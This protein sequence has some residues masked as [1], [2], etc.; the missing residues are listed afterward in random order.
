MP[1]NPQKPKLQK[2]QGMVLVSSLVF[3]FV[4]TLL[5]VSAMSG[6]SL[7]IRM[8]SN[9]QDKAFAFQAAEGAL[10][11]VE[12]WLESETAGQPHHSLFFVLTKAGTEEYPFLYNASNGRAAWDEF[13]WTTGTYGTTN[14]M[15]AAS[16]P[17]RYMIEY[18]ASDDVNGSPNQTANQFIVTV[19]G[20]GANPNSR[21]KIQQQYFYLD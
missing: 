20:Y 11:E 7:E 10:L 4:I 13:E 6:N 1:S 2:Q 16:W 3:L 8:A 17:P 12:D 15:A 21:V 9:A 18:I 14:K 5:G 19:V